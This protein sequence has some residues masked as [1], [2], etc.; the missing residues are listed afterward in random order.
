[1]TSSVDLG[2]IDLP[3]SVLDKA[4]LYASI[5]LEWNKKIRLTG[6]S[7]SEEI[8]AHLIL[9]SFLSLPLLSHHGSSE[10]IDFGSGNGAP[11]LLIALTNPG[12][13]VTLL[14]RIEKKRV[15]L[16]YAAMRLGVSNL[17]IFPALSAPVG[18]PIILMK[19]ITLS[20]LFAEPTIK[21]F[22][23]PPWTLLR[24]G[25]DRHPSCNPISSYVIN[26][27]VKAWGITRSV[28]FTESIHIG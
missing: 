9:E 11:G 19:A 17:R 7:T 28:I 13:Q 27:G 23:A 16:E 26:G 12:R 1:M 20:D 25:T 15:F 5:L 21:V 18:P 10:I 22:A 24:F 8:R 4:D 6:F 3:E 2:W 14:E